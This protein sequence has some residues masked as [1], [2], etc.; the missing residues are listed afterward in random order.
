MSDL[1]VNFSEDKQVWDSF[2]SE[3]PQR[4]IFVYSKF[5]NSLLVDYD[6]VTCY[7]KGKIVAGAVVIYAEPGRPIGS[8]FPFT[9]S[10]GLLLAD[11]SSQAEHSRIAHEFKVA[12]FL[13]TRLAEHYRKFC[14]C[15]SWRLSDLRP[16]Q[17]HNYHRPEQGQFALALRYTGILTLRKY[18]DFDAYVSSVR[19]ARRQEFNKSSK[20][21][22][23]R[24]SDDDDLLV[25]LHARTFERQ[26]IAVADHESALVRSIART[27]IGGGFGKMGCAMVDDLPV[28]AV[29]FLYDDRTAYYLFG[30]NDPSHRKSFGGTFLLMQMIKDA[31]ARKMQEIDFVGVNSPNRG[32]FKTSL[33]AEL[34]PYF[35]TSLSGSH[36]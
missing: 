11:N 33:N 15:Q 32:D 17:W 7:K 1:E 6:L 36:E 23:L 19:V 25:T 20:M 2:V 4:S 34:K 18:A 9:Q 12:E 22:T 3:S 29:L 13:V 14:L 31:F 28:S 27:A 10:Q 26:N 21:L 35:I 16:F 30:A 5:L 8:P 24:I